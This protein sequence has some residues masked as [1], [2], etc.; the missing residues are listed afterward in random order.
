MAPLTSLGIARTSMK[1]ALLAP[2]FET[3]A[4]T[5]CANCDV[6]V[7]QVSPGSAPVSVNTTTTD[8]S[9]NYSI[10]VPPATLSADG[11]SGFYYQVSISNGS[12]SVNTLIAPTESV[13]SVNVAPETSMALTTV[14][15][16]AI[17]EFGMPIEDAVAYPPALLLNAANSGTTAASVS[18]VNE[19]AIFVP[20]SSNASLTTAMANGVVT[21]QTG[22]GPGANNNTNIIMQALRVSSEYNNIVGNSGTAEQAASYLPRAVLTGCSNADG[23]YMTDTAAADLAAS[24]LSGATF[25]FDEV[26]NAY[27]NAYLS[28]ASPNPFTSQSTVIANIQNGAASLKANLQASASSMTAIGKENQLMLTLLRGLDLS[29]LSPSTTFQ[30]DQLLALFQLFAVLQATPGQSCNLGQAGLPFIDNVVYQLLNPPAPSTTPLPLST[31]RAS[32]VVIYNDEGFG[33]GPT[34]G[35]FMAKVLFYPAGKTITDVSISSTDTTALMGGSIALTDGGNNIWVSTYEGVCV[36]H[37]TAVTYTIHVTYSDH[38]TD[39]FTGYDR[40]H[41]LVPEPSNAFWTGSSFTDGS[42]ICYNGDNNPTVVTTT[43]PLNEWESP[44]AELTQLLSDNPNTAASSAIGR[45]IVYTYE[46]SHIDTREANPS[47]LAGCNYV[48]SGTVTYNTNNFIPTTDCDVEACSTASGVPAAD[49]AC[50]INIQTYFESIANNI[51]AKA[52]GNFTCFCVDGV[53]GCGS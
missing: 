39:T 42:K 34:T 10:T 52:A 38:S 12:A 21:T 26:Y 19:G 29:N 3:S 14:S 45:H 50:R 7:Y 53:G 6:N 27:V 49:I 33:C 40:T 8:S 44:V 11:S 35:H 30:A 17:P 41:P 51:L 37:D 20:P 9:G 2:G 15:S 16:I 5:V 32:R 31:A 24:L 36:A 46:F 23:T 28:M 13:S 22:S 4:N 48:S 1:T 25:T 43:R 47:P 18:L